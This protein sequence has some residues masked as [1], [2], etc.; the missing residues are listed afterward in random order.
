MNTLPKVSDKEK[1][2]PVDQDELQIMD[3]ADKEWVEMWKKAVIDKK[4]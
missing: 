3:E 1:F 4:G 2:E